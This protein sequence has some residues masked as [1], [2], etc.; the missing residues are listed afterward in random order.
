[1]AGSRR[2]T[3]QKPHVGFSGL[4]QKGERREERGCREAVRDRG[5]SF[6]THKHTGMQPAAPLQGLSR[7]LPLSHKLLL[8]PPLPIPQFD[9][10]AF[11]FRFLPFTI[12]YPV[13]FRI[14]G[15]ERKV[16]CAAL[17]RPVHVYTHAYTAL[18]VCCPWTRRAG[19][20]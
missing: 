3:N 4:A 13:P 5:S 14:L 6:Y 15:D 2:E 17:C 9:R 11:N 20:T 1:M 12:P 19:S 10:A 8:H 16:G 18:L 7:A